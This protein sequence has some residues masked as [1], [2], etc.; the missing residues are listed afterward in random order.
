MQSV[1]L[2][3]CIALF[4]QKS[5]LCS[6]GSLELFPIYTENALIYSEDLMCCSCYCSPYCSSDWLFHIQLHHCLQWGFVTVSAKELHGI[7]L[8]SIQCFIDSTSLSDFKM[9]SIVKINLEMLL[10]CPGIFMLFSCLFKHRN[11]GWM[12]QS[13]SE[14]RW[15]CQNAYWRELH[16]GLLRSTGCYCELII[17]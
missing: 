11:L 17:Y 2:C 4:T 8:P 5:L 6:V 9:F 13:F 12:R 14:I 3:I 10:R 15:G 7:C 1:T 16:N